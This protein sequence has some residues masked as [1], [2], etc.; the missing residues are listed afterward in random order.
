MHSQFLLDVVIPVALPTSLQSTPMVGDVG[1]VSGFG[2]R[3]DAIRGW[4]LN[5]LKQTGSFRVIDRRRCQDGLGEQQGVI[6]ETHFCTDNE[7]RLCFGDFGSG[8]TVGEVNGVPVLMGI[9]SVITN[10]CH[11]TYPVLYTRVALYTQWIQQQ[12]NG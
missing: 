3:K 12:I 8:L 5:F 6:S 2:L 11:G 4:T 10:M 7:N 9:V 1:V